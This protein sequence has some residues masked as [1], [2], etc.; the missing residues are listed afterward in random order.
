MCQW[1]GGSYAHRLKDIQSLVTHPLRSLSAPT[2]SGVLHLYTLRAVRMSPLGEAIFQ[3]LALRT[4]LASP[5]ITYKQLVSALPPLESPYDGVAHNDE[6][7]YRALSEVGQNCRERNLPVLIA[8]V[9]R[10][11]EKSP[12]LGYYQNFHSEAGNDPAKRHEA[13]ER[14]VERVRGTVYSVSQRTQSS[15]GVSGSSTKERQGSSP[16]G[17]LRVAEPGSRPSLVFTGQITCPRCAAQ[18]QVEVERNANAIT[19]KQPAFALVEAEAA[20]A[21]RAIGHLFIGSILTSPVL[22]YG[23]F[24]HCGTEQRVAVFFNRALRDRT[25]AHLT[26]MPSASTSQSQASADDEGFRLS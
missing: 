4:G 24:V 16:L 12:G 25:D 20:S 11:V 18:L 19:A 3:V 14:E 13:W 8:L 5:L 15:T 1:V 17:M 9:V 2:I 6:R 23:S 22:Y 7:L 21:G 26:I 10:S